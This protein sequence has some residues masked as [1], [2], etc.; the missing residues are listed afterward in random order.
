MANSVAI[1]PGTGANIAIDDNGSG[2]YYQV[3]KQATG[4]NGTYN[5][6]SYTN[7][8]PCGGSTKYISCGITRPANT[9]AYSA[10]QEVSDNSAAALFIS[11]CA[12]ANARS[13]IINSAKLII[14]SNPGTPP[15]IDF[16]IF[17]TSLN[18]GTDQSSFS[19]TQVQMLTMLKSIS[20]LGVN[21]KVISG[22]RYYD[23]EGFSIPFVTGASTTNLFGRVMT[24]SA[25][26]PA[27]N[28]D[29]VRFIL[30]V[31]QD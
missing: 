23:A 9:T 31:Q 29:V 20:F 22:F 30:G 28:S 5:L 13:G 21:S 18:M 27:Q 3:V 6:V 11:G 17:T 12:S 26:T 10:N 24:R 8:L 15:D 25:W 16:M 1:T 2:I 7:P 4:G 14:T 19:I